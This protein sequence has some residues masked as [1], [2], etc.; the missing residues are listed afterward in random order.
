MFFPR[1]ESLARQRRTLLVVGLDPHPELLPQFSARAARDFC[2]RLAEQTAEYAVA[3]K[4]NTAFFEALGAEGWQILEWVVAQ[5]A[6]MLPVILDAKRGDI[7]S[8]ARA[9]ARGLFEALPG[10]AVTLFPHLGRDALEP[11]LAFQDRGLFLLVRTSNPA[12]AEVQELP[13]ATGEPFYLG[14]ARQI[15]TWANPGQVGLVVGATQ[16]QALHRLREA[17]PAHWFLAPGVGAQGGSLEDAYRAGHRA[18]GLGILFPISRGL[19]RSQSPAQTAR[20]LAQRTWHLVES[21]AATPPSGPP[22][23]PDLKRALAHDLVASGCVRFGEFRLKSGQIAPI[24]FDLRRLVGYPQ[25]M[26]RVALAYGHLLRPL[27]F[28]HLAPLPY[29]ALPIGAAVGLLHGWPLV[30]PRKEVKAY[31]TSALVEGA[32]QPGQTAVVLD[33]VLTT[34]ASKVEA[35]ERL[36]A[37]GLRVQDVVVLIDRE[38]GGGRAFL[39]S[40]GLRVHA[41]FTLRELLA[42]WES[43]GQVPAKDLARV[44]AWLEQ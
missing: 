27:K 15:V 8:T 2:L 21:V 22:V 12:A 39:E 30:Y 14:L 44:H 1:L 32:Y 3:F 24:Y 17:A 25:V 31:G 42:Q 33:D 23:P 11:F 19:A 38:A 37:V 9:Y 5:L 29:A 4:V 20:N 40:R 10:D 16:T 26:H 35:L 28:H 36:Q 6:P 41:L 34:G 43:S 7:A 13:L 18:D